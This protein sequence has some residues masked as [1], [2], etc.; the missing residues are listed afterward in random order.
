MLATPSAVL[1]SAGHSEHSVTVIAGVQ[2]DFGNSG[3]ELTYSALT[4][5][6]TI[7]SQASG[8]TGLN[9]CTSGFTAAL[10]VF[11][12]PGEHADR[13]RDQRREHEPGEHRRRGSSGSDRGTSAC[14]CT[15][16]S[17]TSAFG[18][19]REPRGVALALA[20]VE[21]FAPL[22]LGVVLGDQVLRLASTPR[23]APGSCRG[24]SRSCGASA[25]QASSKAPIASSGTPSCCHSS[26]SWRRGS[27]PAARRSSGTNQPRPSSAR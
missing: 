27:S 14:R 25:P 13:H 5:I 11:D 9:S 12:S 20:C 6:V 3:S 8:E 24:S 17:R 1:I 22:S 7:G 4:T 15:G 16:G 23:P 18:I 26:V 21:L 2:N 10:T 19:A